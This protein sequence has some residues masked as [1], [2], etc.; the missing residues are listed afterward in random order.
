MAGKFLKLRKDAPKI[1]DA[2]QEFNANGVP[3]SAL[4]DLQP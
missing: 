1:L 2:C 3:A 4:L